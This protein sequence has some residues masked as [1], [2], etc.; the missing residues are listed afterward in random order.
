MEG[1]DMG[2]I[3]QDGHAYRIADAHTHIYKDKIAEKASA[4]IGRFYDTDMSVSVATGDTLIEKGSSIGVE[5]YLVCSAATTLDQVDIINP[6]IA[7]E[8]KKH[9]EFI[10]LGTAHQ[11]VCDMDALLDE[12]QA[13]G[14][15]G[16]KLHP[17]FQRFDI[18]DKRMIPL[19]RGAAQR[20]LVMLF[21]VGD[22]RYEFSSPESLARALE[23][24]PDMKCQAAHFGCCKLWTRRPLALEGADIMYDTSSTLPWTTKEE[25]LDLIDHIGIDRLMWGT[26][27]P[28]WDHQ[29]ELCRFLD[30]GLSPEDNQAILYDN[31]ARFYGI[32]E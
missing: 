13:L 15:R 28:M 12:I 22:D 25:A 27:F 30:L 31:F 7:A 21:H 18:D 29:K 8:C 2:Y 24:V 26:D 32:E 19:Y 17:D 3:A 16:I 9:P 20:G 6:F 10:G 1:H 23:L 5:K 11:D 4:V 14:L